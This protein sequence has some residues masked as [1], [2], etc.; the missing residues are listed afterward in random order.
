[1]PEEIIELSV[2]E[3]NALRAKLGLKP[4]R[5]NSEPAAS[6]SS[7][8]SEELSLSID[9]SNALRQKLGLKP[10][11]VSNS[12]FQDLPSG[13]KASEAIH[14]PA[15]NASEEDRIKERLAE[16]KLK[17]EVEAGIAKFQQDSKEGDEKIDALSWADQM[18]SKSAAKEKEKKR[19]GAGARKD[20]SAY[21]KADE[22]A[23]TGSGSYTDADFDQQN[24]TVAHNTSDFDA[25]T[26]TVLTLADKS[27]LEAEE[28]GE[29]ALENVN[30]SESATVKDNLKRKRM[31]E[32]GLGHAGGYAGYDD[33]EFEELGGSQ[34]TLGIDSTAR[35]KSGVGGA[36]GGNKR[37]GFKLGGVI[38]EGNK[39]AANESDLFASFKGRSVSL[40]SSNENGDTH[41]A[42][43]MSYEEEEAMG[44]NVIN[45]EE[46]ERKR[47]KKE[48]KLLKKLKK[49]KKKN[50]K[51]QNVDELDE[52]DQVED[53]HALHP[54]G[55]D[56]AEQLNST[57]SLLEELSANSKPNSKK[58]RRRKR[59]VEYDSNDSDAEVRNVKTQTQPTSNSTK[60]QS[61]KTEEEDDEAMQE[62]RKDKFHDIMEK[63]NKRTQAIFAAQNRSPNAGNGDEL[64]EVEDDAFLSAA[65][66]KARR[67]QRLRQ[68]SSKSSDVKQSKD[69][70][71]AKGATAVVEALQSMKSNGNHVTKAATISG[72]GKI[73]FELGTTTEFTR[74]LRAQPTKANDLNQNQTEQASTIVE[75][76]NPSVVEKIEVEDVDMKEVEDDEYENHQ[77]LE[78]LADQV[79]EEDAMDTLG[80]TGSTVGVGRGMS[81]FLGM[82][83]QTGEISGKTSG[84]EELRGR[85]KDEKTYEDYAPLDLKNV[86]KLD[87]TGLT[88][89][90][91]EKDIEFA[92]REIKLEYR[93]EHGRLLTRK[94]AFR[95]LCYQFHGH[96]SS[97]KK[98]E[99]RLQQI[100]REQHERSANTSTAGTLGA[101]KATQKA[102]GKAFVLHKTS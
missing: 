4:L 10:L 39:E 71:S 48:K 23:M 6:S 33:D 35:G 75:K 41:Q 62:E 57:T 58:R 96:G 32:M 90:R 47:K 63:G 37:V 16:A 66:S 1:M 100:E 92:N 88:G 26:T 15:Q 59:R 72:E 55:A 28:D 91:P 93:D 9:E 97:K 22:K 20:S 78:E 65:I 13:R 21:G 25:G 52:Y 14:A 85:A 60:E 81:A 17:R 74:A 61:I 34:M 50:R 49:H 3:S 24:L 31:V 68:L 83:K 46:L 42:D 45:K 54:E 102:T 64:E 76:P 101:L 80:S 19:P 18:R 82:L 56:N 53:H 8:K 73:T 40:A 70:K 84:R 43:F 36:G 94:E 12:N 30:L 38:S 27:I 7:N 79:K 87:T 95:Q 29:N 89:K 77:T 99:K 98:E 11:K 2:E 69:I 5:I 67:L 51:E 86:V 44:L